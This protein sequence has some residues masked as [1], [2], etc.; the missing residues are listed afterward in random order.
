MATVTVMV[1]ATKFTCN[2]I[3]QSMKVKGNSFPSTITKSPPPRTLLIKYTPHAIDTSIESPATLTK[4][5]GDRIDHSVTGIQLRLSLH[6]SSPSPPTSPSRVPTPKTNLA[7][8]HACTRK[9]TVHK[10]NG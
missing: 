9:Q 3:D 2:R 7:K 1:M 10:A 5:A 4:F 8:V 6:L